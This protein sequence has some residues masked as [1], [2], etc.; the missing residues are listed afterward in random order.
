MS[1]LALDAKWLRHHPLPH[2]PEDTD[3]NSRGQVMLVGGSRMV[4]GGVVLTAEAA[5]R[6]GAGKVQIALPEPLAIPAG[7][8]LPEAGFFPLPATLDGEIAGPGDL[9]ERVGRCGCLAIGPAIGSTPAAGLV[10]D[11]LLPVADMTVILDAA[12]VAAAADRHGQVAA[13]DGRAI[14][15]PHVGEMAQLTGLAAEDIEAR[16]DE[17]VADYA[18]RLRAVVLI[19]GAT[20]IIANPEGE[21]IVYAGGGVGLATG[22]S[23]DVLTGAI[24]GLSARGLPPWEATC[25]GV[26]LHGEAG[27]RL[28][29]RL[30]PMGF[31]ARELP[32]EFPSLMRGV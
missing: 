29:E 17:I 3:K 1:P 14:L 11:A 22:G 30:G 19:K 4:P 20:T 18:R 16:R 26:W 21:L 8:S 7:F 15:T 31:M 28:A 27:R 9:A 24:A 2:H 12:A 13:L 23:G 10:L 32:A 25:W 5:F 6:A